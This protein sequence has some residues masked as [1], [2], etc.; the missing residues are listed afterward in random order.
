MQR[1]ERLGAD[2][3]TEA[4]HGLGDSKCVKDAKLAPVTGALIN[5][6]MTSTTVDVD[7]IDIDISRLIAPPECALPAYSAQS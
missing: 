4:A 1:S 6:I 7:V 5:Y 2:H 3:L